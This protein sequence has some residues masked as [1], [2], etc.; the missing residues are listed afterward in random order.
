V[1]IEGPAP[2]LP[3]VH[4]QSSEIVAVKYA[5]EGALEQVVAEM[6]LALV[7]HSAEYRDAKR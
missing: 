2:A 3:S 1:L 5:P 7:N 6:S 4:Q